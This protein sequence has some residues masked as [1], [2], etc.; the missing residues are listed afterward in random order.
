MEIISLTAIIHARK[1]QK[2]IKDLD[3]VASCIAIETCLNT[4][5]LNDLKELKVLKKELNKTLKTLK[6]LQNAEKKG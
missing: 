5:N 6:E 4:L 1:Q 3:I 2:Q